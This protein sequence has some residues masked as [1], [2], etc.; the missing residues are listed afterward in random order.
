M[1]KYSN[2]KTTNFSLENQTDW[3]KAIVHSI[4]DGVLVIDHEGI[5]RLI[6]PKYIKLTGVTSNI[7]G[8]P[9]T[10][11]RPGAQLPETLITRKNR[12]EVYRKTGNR[13]YIADMDP[14]LA[15]VY[16]KKTFCTN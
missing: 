2:L 13:E 12:V 5:V 1:E 15:S 6:N 9:L 11:T 14:T 7:I 16:N 10:E 8:K 3:W 4:N